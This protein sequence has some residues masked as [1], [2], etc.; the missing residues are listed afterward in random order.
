M[1]FDQGITAD[2]LGAASTPTGTDRIL[3]F[4]PSNVAAQTTIVNF[5]PDQL[6]AYVLAN[7]APVRTASAPAPLIL[8]AANF[9]KTLVAVSNMTVQAPPSPGAI[10][11]NN[12]DGF[13]MNLINPNGYTI[14][15]A[16][17]T[18]GQTILAP[19][20]AGSNSTV[21]VYTF[22]GVQVAGVLYLTL[23]MPTPG[24]VPVIPGQVSGLTMGTLASTTASLSWTAA[25]VGGAVANYRV[26]YRVNGVIPW[27]L[28]SAVVVPGATAYTVTGLS[29]VTL[30]N[31]IV[32][33]TNGAGSGAASA[34]VNGTTAG[35]GGINS[36]AFTG[37][38]G[39][40]TGNQIMT[41][42][43]GS[44]LTGGALDGAGRVTLPTDIN[45]AGLFTALGTRGDGTFTINF[46]GPVQSYVSMVTYIRAN[47]AGTTAYIIDSAPGNGH[48][49]V[50][51]ILNGAQTTLLANYSATGALVGAI[52]VTVTGTTINV[53]WDGVLACSV[54]DGSILPPGYCGVGHGGYNPAPAMFVSSVSF[55]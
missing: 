19:G 8:G 13:W 21:G 49:F 17:G 3:G 14:T 7:P 4:Q 1:S 41:P 31:F 55:A 12:G 46:T 37:A 50:Y 27:S 44:Q 45:D 47:V 33:A 28:A 29:P 26:E 48:V 40:L 22:Y 38:A 5:T 30:Y 11:L 2:A 16:T 23:Q 43:G 24:A 15:F 34:T 36:I 39:P 32:T 54:A 9:G 18:G 52:T 53:F 35:G 51:R 6:A 25:A 10:G 42:V 20:G